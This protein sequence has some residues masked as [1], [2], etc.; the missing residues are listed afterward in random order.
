MLK[1]VDAFIRD[2][3]LLA[4][5]SRLVVGV[6]GGPDSVCLL[7]ILHRLSSRWGWSLVVAHLEHGLRGASSIGDALF[8]QRLANDLGW[9]VII[10]QRD[11]KSIILQQGG[12]M[13]DVC[14]QERHEFLQQTA[15]DWD[16]QAVLLAHHQ[17][18]QAET[19]LLHLLR[20]AGLA[21]LSGMAAR[22][23]A[24]GDI[25]LVRP[26]LGESRAAI[27]D[28]LREQA[29]GFRMDAS[30]AA[31]DYVRNRLRLDVMPLL[32]TIN[33]ETEAT[34][35]RTAKV[36][37]AEDRYLAGLA[38]AAF[39]DVSCLNETS[40][41]LKISP[42]ENYPQALQR[43]ILRLAWQELTGGPQDLAF[44]HVEAAL[45]LLRQEVG[46]VTSWPLDWQVRRSYDKLIL[47][48]AQSEADEAV[49]LLPIPGVVDLANGAGQIVASV[50]SAFEFEGYSSD[51]NVAYCDLGTLATSQLQVRYWRAGD[52][53]SPLGLGGSKKLQDY[54]TDVK[55]DRRLRR[56]V[57]IVVCGKQIVWVAGYRLDSRWRLTSNSERLLRLEYKR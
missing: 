1:R 44:M 37:Q 48:S 3:S 13:Q 29:I 38:Q 57:P 22:D 36:L 16:A 55:L 40:L 5:G 51:P 53:F 47:E 11:I 31:S 35:A 43:R 34:L 27:M 41:F 18:D 2:N 26:L 33:P 46:S 50:L 24:L 12:S 21:G 19:V 6:S 25:A 30:N 45:G 14:R 52:I 9:P 32:R 23:L 17:G 10:A 56:R 54:F 28:Y 8:V 39:A 42:L 20:G 49:H 4:P 7:H 15:R